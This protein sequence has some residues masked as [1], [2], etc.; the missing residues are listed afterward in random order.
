MRKRR[1]MRRAISVAALSMTA[2]SIERLLAPNRANRF[3]AAWWQTSWR[4]SWRA[5]SRGII[6]AAGD[7]RDRDACS[8]LEKAFRNSWEVALRLLGVCQD[9][10]GPAGGEMTRIRAI[11]AGELELSKTLALI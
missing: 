11:F 1:V 7:R 4:A 5:L 3:I 2:I 6:G 8:L 9:R 10:H